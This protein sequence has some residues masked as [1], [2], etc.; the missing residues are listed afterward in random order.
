MIGMVAVS[1]SEVTGVGNVDLQR[2]ISGATDE[3]AKPFS[4]KDL[5]IKKRRWH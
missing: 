2:H 4:Q 1:A 3:A 5:Q